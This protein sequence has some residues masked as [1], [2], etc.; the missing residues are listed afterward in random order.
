MAL[1]YPHSLG[2][3]QRVAPPSFSNLD[4]LQHLIYHGNEGDIPQLSLEYAHAHTLS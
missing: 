3:K 2:G 1:F 4:M